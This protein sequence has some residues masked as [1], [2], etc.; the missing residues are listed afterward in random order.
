[1]LRKTK[2]EYRQKGGLAKGMKSYNVY[3]PYYGAIDTVFAKNKKVA[4]KKAHKII[5]IKRRK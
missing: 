2:R 3:V 4:L 5:R 1:M